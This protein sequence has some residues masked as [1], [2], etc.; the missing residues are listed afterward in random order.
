[1]QALIQRLKSKTY[2]F[3]ALLTVLGIVQANS[4]AF[5]QLMTP[6]VAGIFTAVVGMVVGILRELTKLPINDK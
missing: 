6:Q 1:M 5:T 2:L 4:G 3:A